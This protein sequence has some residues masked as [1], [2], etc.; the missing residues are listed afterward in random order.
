[1]TIKVNGQWV[2]CVRNS[3]Y[4]FIPSLLKLY[5]S[6]EHALKIRMWFG[7]NL[8]FNF[9]HFFEVWFSRFS[10]IYTKKVHVVWIYVIH[11]KIINSLNVL[12]HIDTETVAYMRLH[13][14]QNKIRSENYS[15]QSNEMC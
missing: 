13:S 1:M 11:S 5:S 8:H 12:V 14:V 10:G 15:V 4:S 7:Y 6:L 3:S 9:Y 2:P